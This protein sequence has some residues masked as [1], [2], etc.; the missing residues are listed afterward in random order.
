MN[1][2]YVSGIY[3]PYSS[4]G[5]RAFDFIPGSSGNNLLFGT[6]EGSYSFVSYFSGVSTTM[7]YTM[8][9]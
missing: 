6:R 5:T 9:F 8:R 1:L 2:N 4:Y 3:F 7:T